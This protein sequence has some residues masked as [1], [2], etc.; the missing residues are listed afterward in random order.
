MWQIRSS[1]VVQKSHLLAYAQKEN[2]KLALSS[3]KE[4]KI[5]ALCTF[6]S[7]VIYLQ[8]LLWILRNTVILT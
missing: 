2:M 3:F 7:S 8:E 6:I 5:S 4:D 1:Q